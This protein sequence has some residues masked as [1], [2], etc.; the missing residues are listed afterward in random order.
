MSDLPGELIHLAELLRKSTVMESMPRLQLAS[1]SERD[2][3][4]EAIDSG[5][6]ILANL[7]S[8]RNAVASISFLPDELLADIFYHVMMQDPWS[9]KWTQLIL[10]CRRWNRI[11]INNGRLWSW[12]SDHNSMPIWEK[13][14]KGCPLSYKYNHGYHPSMFTRNS[15][16]IR[17]LELDG[18]Y[19]DFAHFFDDVKYMPMLQTLHI[20][21]Y[22]PIGD[23]PPILWHVPSFIVEGGAP[24][25]RQV[26]LH[27]V[28]FANKLQLGF[29][30]SLT[31][32][33]LDIDW[34]SLGVLFSVEDFYHIVER[35]P[36]LQTL[37]VRYFIEPHSAKDRSLEQLPQ[38]SLPALQL[39]DLHMDI[40]LIITILQ[41]LIIPPNA[42]TVFVAIP[43]LNVESSY[44]DDIKSLLIP[45][46]RKLRHKDAWVLRSA[47]IECG[48]YLA[49]SVSYNSTCPNAILGGHV[50]SVA[51][52]VLFYPS[53]QHQCRQ[54]LAKI[55]NAFPLDNLELFNAGPVTNDN[56]KSDVDSSHQ[57][58]SWETWRTLIRLLPP[59]LTIRIGVN[60]GML[61]LLHGVI[62]AME[63]AP[64]V[65]PH[66]RRRKRQRRSYGFGSFP[67]S[68]LI[69]VESLNVVLL[70]S[71][72]QS[73]I[74]QEFERLYSQLIA[75]LTTFRDLD[76][77]FKPTG[78]PLGV[79]A[80]EEETLHSSSQNTQLFEVT[81]EVS[82]NGRIWD[83]VEER[84]S[85]R[86]AKKYKKRLIKKFPEL[87][88][89]D[90]DTDMSP[91]SSD[92]DDEEADL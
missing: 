10:V 23:E 80:I 56:T 25:L 45:I 12:I 62:D 18:S 79:L 37:K 69:L 30:A 41:F 53:T 16:R 46:R 2:S 84:K 32:L 57:Q 88:F 31:R 68:K 85:R 64:R 81:G 26:R 11:A 6:D 91:L 21:L 87:H 40:Q 24:C 44:L 47:L 86:S 3:I 54:M 39:L 73:A 13:R 38:I 9:S 70:R 43:S 58:F 17:I 14:S 29:L 34:Q 5:I 71:P 78:Q 15:H 76:T 60:N 61:A 52:Q 51:A 36:G 74:S 90:S 33:E 82:F 67:L 8:Y 28:S 48:Y 27:N 42:S 1:I 92:S 49:F 77:G 65:F 20:D 4:R 35:S 59:R 22:Y 55:I 83:P 63:R 72:G 89:P 19:Q 7:K 75:Y 66:G 50:G